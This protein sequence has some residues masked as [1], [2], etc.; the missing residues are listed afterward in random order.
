MV[1]ALNLNARLLFDLCTLSIDTPMGETRDKLQANL[2]V[3]CIRE[4]YGVNTSRSIIIE[5]L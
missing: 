2:T 5:K 4:L 3:H 1:Y